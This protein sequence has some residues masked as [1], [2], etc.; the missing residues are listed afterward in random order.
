VVGSNAQGLSTK[1]VEINVIVTAGSLIVV[2]DIRGGPVDLRIW[3]DGKVLAGYAPYIQ[4]K[5]G[6]QVK[7]VADQSV[8]IFTGV[9]KYTYVT[10]NGVPLGR[11][12]PTNNPGS[13]RITAFGPPTPSNDR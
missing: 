1:P 2:I 4:Y 10:V 9:A 7:I 5:S 11:L 3:K 6:K 12:G 8:W 13:W